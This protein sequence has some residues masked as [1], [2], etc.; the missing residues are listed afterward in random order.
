MKIVKINLFLSILFLA[1]FS[2]SDNDAS[3]SIPEEF[4]LGN[5]ELDL[6][7]KS[8]PEYQD[9]YFSTSKLDAFT[10]KYGNDLY[11]GAFYFS[12]NKDF[13][14][15]RISS[16]SYEDKLLKNNK[17]IEGKDT[18]TCKTCRSPKCGE[19]VIKKAVGD[20]SKT[21][22]ISIKPIK[23]LGIHTGTEICYSSSP[24]ASLFVPLPTI[25]PGERIELGENPATNIDALL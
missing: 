16:D 1:I 15:V 8:F 7:L 25:T 5:L 19:E 21:V 3:D 2:C 9:V 14:V 22:Y 23:T 6:S 20:G 4:K 17:E 10:E 11:K 24:I 12:S 13:T 18:K